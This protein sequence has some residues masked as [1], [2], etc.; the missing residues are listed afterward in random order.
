MK[1]YIPYLPAV[2]FLSVGVWLFFNN[3]HFRTEARE[4][5]RENESLRAAND[6]LHT[7]NDSLSKHNEALDKKIAAGTVIYDSLRTKLQE[8]NNKSIITVYE[9]YHTVTSLDL[10]GQI[11]FLSGFLSEADSIPR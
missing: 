10:D 8:L 3:K 4:Y 1:K 7:L 11:K 6:S 2:V 5:K 9:D